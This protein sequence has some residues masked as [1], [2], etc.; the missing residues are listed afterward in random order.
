LTAILLSYIINNRAFGR[1]QLPH[2]DRIL[3]YATLCPGI[4]SYLVIKGPSPEDDLDER[5]MIEGV[6]GGDPAAEKTF[7]DTHVDRVYRLAYRMTGDATLAEDFTQDTFMRALDR[8]ST[9]EGRSALS[10]WL[11]SVAVSVILNGLRKV[12]RYQ[13]REE[14]WDNFESVSSERNTPDHE[15]TWWLTRA[16]DALPDRLRLVFVMHDMEGYKHREIS[17]IL[18]IPVGTSKARLAR[19]HEKLRQ[20][21]GIAATKNP[22]EVDS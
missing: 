22:E 16:I 14:G 5:Q 8:I 18:N 3:K 9:F 21:L 7:Y 20:T 10:S 6:L 4:V 15:L 17:E 11:H 2:F 19:A 12:R 1:V 13:V